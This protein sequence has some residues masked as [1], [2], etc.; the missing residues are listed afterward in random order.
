MR[1]P[2]GPGDQSIANQR[3][4]IST[5]STFTYRKCLTVTGGP[6]KRDL[7]RWGSSFAFIWEAKVSRPKSRPL[8]GLRFFYYRNVLGGAVAGGFARAIDKRLRDQ[9]ERLSGFTDL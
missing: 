6:Y 9:Y 3:P 4:N 7:F 8:C 5:L 2:S 1:I